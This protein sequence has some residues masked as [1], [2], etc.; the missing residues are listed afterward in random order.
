M[1]YDDERLT[2][3]DDLT[4]TAHAMAQ[5]GDKAEAQYILKETQRHLHADPGHDVGRSRAGARRPS[6]GAEVS[7]RDR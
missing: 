3:I 5:G 7:D 1:F 2:N 4:D 6:R